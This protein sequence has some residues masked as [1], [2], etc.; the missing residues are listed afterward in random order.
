MTV[1]MDIHG[2]YYGHIVDWTKPTKSGVGSWCF[3]E[4][5]GTPSKSPTRHQ[6]AKG[7]LST[8]VAT[9]ILHGVT[10]W[11]LGSWWSIDGNTHTHTHTWAKLY[12]SA[13][14]RVHSSGST[15]D[16]RI[17]SL[18]LSVRT[19]SWRCKLATKPFALD[20]NTATKRPVCKWRG[21]LTFFWLG[22]HLSASFTLN[23][24]EWV[25]MDSNGTWWYMITL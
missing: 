5:S 3:Q 15:S 1:T 12:G 6:R 22:W 2:R 20:L 21:P 11:L 9:S 16:K 24:F 4:M 7:A 10:A 13:T 8:Q 18:S 17:R 14:S 19:P 25:R 23:G